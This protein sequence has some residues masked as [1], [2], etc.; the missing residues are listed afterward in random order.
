LSSKPYILRLLYIVLILLVI[1]CNT[2]EKTKNV[3]SSQIDSTSKIMSAIQIDT[4]LIINEIKRNYLFMRNK[5]SSAKI[6]ANYYETS[7]IDTSSY[8]FSGDFSASTNWDTTFYITDN[9][10]LNTSF[11]KEETQMGTFYYS[12]ESYYKNNE[13]FFSFNQEIYETPSSLEKSGINETRT[14]Y[15]KKIPIKCLFRELTF[16]DISVLRDSINKIGSNN[17]INKTN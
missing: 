14:Y 1:S 5:K 3:N 13:L 11:K 17:C 9:Y 2:S 12:Y 16:D 7:N 10:T 15:H 8:E 4:T 6:K